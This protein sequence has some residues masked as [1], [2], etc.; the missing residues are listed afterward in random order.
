MIKRNVIAS[1]QLK[2][3]E[4]HRYYSTH[5]FK[6][7]AALHDA[8]HF[9]LLLD[10]SSKGL[11]C[12]ES[13]PSS[14]T[15]NPVCS[16]LCRSGFSRKADYEIMEEGKRG[17]S[18]HS[19]QKRKGVLNSLMHIQPQL[20]QRGA[21]FAYLRIQNRDVWR[22]CETLG[23]VSGRTT[24]NKYDL[25]SKYCLLHSANT[26]LLYSLVS[27]WRPYWDRLIQMEKR[28]FGK[29]QRNLQKLWATF[30]QH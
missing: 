25:C 10:G 16:A 12:R 29:R 30:L 19:E 9:T 17:G 4:V 21:V 22:V 1:T 3:R 28:C 20:L 6:T 26:R 15:Q 27:K 24:R 11:P 2:I 8:S 23:W 13:T 18:G 14:Q 5:T 7:T